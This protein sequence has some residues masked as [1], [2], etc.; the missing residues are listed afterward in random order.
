MQHRH[1][2]DDV[3]DAG[4]FGAGQLT[5]RGVLGYTVAGAL[6]PIA[7]GSSAR[8][9]AMADPALR[10][11]YRF[12][13]GDM[14]VTM[15]D[16]ASFTFPAPA[17][18]AN[19]PEGSIED[20]L[21]RFGLPTDFVTLHLQVTLVQSGGATVLI[22]T[23]MGDVT[24]PGNQP[25]NGRLLRSLAAVGVAAEDVT[26]VILSHGH[27]D[28]IG[29]CALGGAPTFPKAAYFMP[30]KELEFWTAKPGPDPSFANFML[31]VGNA[32]LEPVR[33]RIRPYKDGDRIAPGITAVA[34][35]GHTLDHHAFLLEGGG[36]A[37]LHM[38]DAAVHWLVGPEEPE[39]ALAVE[40]DPTAAVA[41]RRKLFGM[42][43]ARHLPV[44][45]YHFPFPG[46]G[47]VV[48]EGAGWRFV[49]V[50]I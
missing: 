14:T 30:P 3:A 23:G 6:L 39:W 45:G 28:H 8:A 20:F 21:G 11:V 10:A 5:R 44:I 22:D 16:D 31:G 13:L 1:G 42:A 50:S 35:P 40:M 19:Q 32:Q 47:M 34:A 24:F 43:A 38:V 26:H 7:A 27:P 9:E 12:S 36:R 15:I 49:P 25:D 4:T 33:D 17:F 48:E 29:A 46:I 41:T 2:R 18:A 37:V